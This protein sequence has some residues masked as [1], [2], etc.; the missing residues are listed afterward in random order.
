MTDLNNSDII[1]L[2]SLVLAMVAI[3]IS[4]FQFRKYK[5]SNPTELE[6]AEELDEISKEL[7]IDKGW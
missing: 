5:T 1:G 3:F 7:I 6:K 4:I 2:I